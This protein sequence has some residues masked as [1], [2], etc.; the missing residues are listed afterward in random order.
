MLKVHK[1]K[2]HWKNEHK[3][4]IIQMKKKLKKGNLGLLLGSKYVPVDVRWSH[5]TTI[6][7]SAFVPSKI[8]PLSSWFV[9]GHKRLN[10]SKTHSFC[11]LQSKVFS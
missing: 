11:E 2:M 5:K 6:C 1:S 3:Y 7:I 9:T 8:M 4:F 10:D